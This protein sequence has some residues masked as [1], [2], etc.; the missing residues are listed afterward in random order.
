MTKADYVIVGGGSAG[1]TLASRLSENPA[2]RIV[3]IEAGPDTPPD[4]TPADIL[5][6]FPSSSLN[7]DY[8]W[9]GL[10]ATRR[11]GG[12]AYPFPQARIMGGGSSVMG[13]WALRGMPS[14]FDNWALAGAAGWSWNDV[15]PYFRKIEND[16]DR[17]G[18]NRNAGR[19]TIRHLPRE[20][21][22][23]FVNAI[24][25]AAAARGLA[26]IADINEQPGDGFF[27]MPISHG[28]ARASSAS[29]YLTI[30]VRQRPNLKIVTKARV[31][32]LLFE[33]RRACGVTLEQSGATAQ[34][35]AHEIILCAGAVHSPAILLRAGI[36]PAEALKSHGIEPRLDCRGVGRQLQNHP[37]LHFALTLPARSRLRADLR[38]F[39]VAG[40]R[41]SSGLADCPRSD[42]LLFTLARVSPHAYGTALAMVGAALYAPFSRG[43]VTL[44]GP[45]PAT[46]PKIDF[47]LLQD[48]R[49]PPRLVAAA[50][51][52]EALL[53]DG[54]VAT[55]FHDAYLLPPVMALNQFNRPGLV[56]ALFAA[57]AK[58]LLDAPAFVSRTV[59]KQVL[60]P[61]RWL[62]NRHAKST[63][64]DGDIL[65]SAAPMGHVTSTCA[66]G[67]PDDPLAVVDSQCRVY[68]IDNLR[69]VDASVMPSV[70]SA[71]TNLPTIMIAERVADMIAA[72]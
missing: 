63:V 48:P 41:L 27:P 56:G 42:L 37:Y 68:G 55:S 38:R 16:L 46:P 9:P 6:T 19:Y 60:K 21:W 35:E 34:I 15:A 59:L 43:S 28:A 4:A 65:S 11:P 30:A 39:A 2:S 29:A 14:D 7:P 36:G 52:A 57:A 67:C 3:L 8:F 71:N 47:C 70:P 72:R 31:T 18:G 26:T 20:E 69:V 51:F 10:V 40:L 58:A 66:I 1:A 12:A 17:D 25:H 54:T 64:S 32:G 53:F 24:E 44:N 13:M 22:P 23:S 45:D 33:G 50:R 49:D 61:G 5:D 62:G